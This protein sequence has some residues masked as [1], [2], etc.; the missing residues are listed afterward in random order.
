MYQIHQSHR[1]DKQPL[2]ADLFPYRF[3]VAYKRLYPAK[4]HF[5][6]LI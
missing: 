6:L 4:N 3:E 2:L 1:Y 5:H